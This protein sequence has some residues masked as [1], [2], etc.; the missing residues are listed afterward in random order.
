MLYSALYTKEILC[1]IIREEK[2]TC[3]IL[4]NPTDQK[5]CGPHHMLCLLT[6][7]M[8]LPYLLLFTLDCPHGNY[9]VL[10]RCGVTNFASYLGGSRFILWLFL[11]LVFP[12]RQTRNNTWIWLHPVKL[13]CSNQPTFRRYV[14]YVILE[15]AIQ[16]YGGQ[17]RANFVINLST[18]WCEWSTAPFGRLAV[19]KRS[20][21]RGHV[22]PRSCMDFWWRE[23]SFA[24]T[25]KWV[26][27]PPSSSP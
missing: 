23:I 25:N 1:L 12:Y 2:H 9:T 26:M 14:F 5:Y 16:A 8:L 13:T 22:E 15:H 24:P 20:R 4:W 18:R 6:Q 11:M 21:L 7:I 27:F 3:S 10:R 19:R 17:S